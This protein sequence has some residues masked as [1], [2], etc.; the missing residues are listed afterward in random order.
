MRILEVFILKFQAVSKYQLPA[1]IQKCKASDSSAAGGHQ[2][3]TNQKPGAKSQPRALPSSA[4]AGQS[5]APGQRPMKSPGA[6]GPDDK[7]RMDQSLL[8]CMYAA[9]VLYT[10]KHEVMLHDYCSPV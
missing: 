9:T 7:V 1:L 6:E 2:D 3:L 5:G 8:L 4:Q 10:R